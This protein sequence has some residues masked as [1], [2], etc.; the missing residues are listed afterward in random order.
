MIIDDKF[1]GTNFGFDNDRFFIDYNPAGRMVGTLR[2]EFNRRAVEL[3]EHV[4]NLLLGISSGLDSQAVMH[5]FFTQGIPI[6]YAFLYHPNCNDIELE[7][8]RI[9]EKKYNFQSTIVEI[10]AFK[11]KDEVMH[12][13]RELDLPPNQILH[14]KFLE[15]LPT[16]RSIIQGIHG[17]DFFYKNNTWHIVETANSFEIARLRSFQTVPGRTGKIIGWERTGPITL[18]LLL[19]D[20]VS[21][22]LKSYRYISQNGLMYQNGEKIPFIDN[23]DLYIKPFIYGKYWGEE[24]EYFPK[25]QGPEKIHYIMNGPKHQYNKNVTAISYSRLI[26]HLESGTEAL[27]IYEIGL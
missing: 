17:P 19:D 16:D 8:L 2:Q 25:Y 13:H 27:R 24:L 26:K 9:L 21:A 3:Y 7:Q 22:F 1:L 23:W 10:D 20:V 5:S 4:P 18:S 15:A 11:I 14:R 6:E 12:L